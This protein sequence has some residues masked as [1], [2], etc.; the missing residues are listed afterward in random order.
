MSEILKLIGTESPIEVGKKIN[1]IVEKKCD[2]NVAVT[3]V[4]STAV[5]SAVTPV[6]CDENG[7]L[8]STEKSIANDRFDGQWVAKEQVLSTATAV[9][10]YTIDLSD[11]LPNDNYNYEILINGRLGAVTNSAGHIT[12]SYIT[13][14]SGK[15][16]INSFYIGSA[17]SDGMDSY[18][19]S[20]PILSSNRNFKYRIVTLKQNNAIMNAMMYRRIGVNT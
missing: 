15:A 2:S 13:E 10:T 1:E 20:I 4:K 18:C 6:Y 11:Y 12:S 8:Q 7:N 19:F 16:L 14:I 3:H 5:G 17:R 9:G